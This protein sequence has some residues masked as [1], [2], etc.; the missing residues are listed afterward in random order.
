MLEIRLI[1]TWQIAST[2]VVVFPV[3]GGPNIIYGAG[4]DELFKIF[5][6]AVFCSSL[7]AILL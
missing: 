6:T 2:N 7:F 5:F 4:Y 1:Y 3:P